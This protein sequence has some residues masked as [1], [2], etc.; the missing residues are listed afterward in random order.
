MIQPPISENEAARKNPLLRLVFRPGATHA[1]V[2]AN[3]HQTSVPS[4]ALVGITMWVPG[5]VRAVKRFSFVVAAVATILMA[6][7]APG[8]ADAS[9]C[10]ELFPDVQWVTQS[11]AGPT[12]MA[13]AGINQATADR[14]AIDVGRVATLVQTEL[15]GLEGSAVC[16]ATAEQAD[17]FSQYAAPGQRLH[18]AAFGEEKVLALAAVET[19]MIDDAIAFGIPHIALWSVGEELELE[20][21][22]PDPLGSTIAHW[23][24]AR[25]NGRLDRY[26]SELIITLFLD[27]PNPEERTAAD[28]VQWV[29]DQKSE[30]F[31]FDPQFIGSQMGVFVDFAVSEEGLDILR[32][33][34][35]ATWADLEKRWRIWIRDQYPRGN[36]GVWWGVGIF[37]FFIVLA[38]ALALLRRREKRLAAVK[39][40]TPPPDEK[41]FTPASAVG[42]EDEGLHR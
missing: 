30:P 27:D 10:S 31:L 17:A 36:Y 40:P 39:R 2:E 20:N 13:T 18:V 35:Q 32:E 25:E 4:H 29:S 9:R 7:P 19:R 23:Y 37:V 34:D 28:A 42:G 21:G 15:G 38:I 6:S 8:M 22:Y 41:L 5:R 16:L 14:F 26:R 33:T 12:T 1:D 24:L 11:V 3:P